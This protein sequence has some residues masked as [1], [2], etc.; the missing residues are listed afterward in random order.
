MKVRRERF[1]CSASFFRI[2]A[3]SF[4]SVQTEGNAEDPIRIKHRFTIVASGNS[5]RELVRLA[6]TS[7]GNCCGLLPML[8]RSRPEG[9]A[10][11][12]SK[13]ANTKLAVG[14]HDSSNGIV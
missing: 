8:I 10:L 5:W 13:A 7:N 4:L 12:N 1:K 11:L 14:T 3:V 6:L 2:R 9:A